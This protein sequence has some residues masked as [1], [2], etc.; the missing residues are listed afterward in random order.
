MAKKGLMVQDDKGNLY[1]LR[2]EILAEAKLD[3]SL[4]E[5]A[6]VALKAAK[7]TA[8]ATPKLKVLGALSLVEPPAGLKAASARTQGARAVALRGA[9]VISRPSI[10]SKG[11]GGGSTIMCPW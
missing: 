7:K 4:H 3:K 5:D 1:F 11:G 2:P 10:G 9:A 8:A 6:K